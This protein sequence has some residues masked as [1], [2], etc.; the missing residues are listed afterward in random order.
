MQLQ[1]SRSNQ[2]TTAYKATWTSWD[3]WLVIV[4]CVG[5]VKFICL[6]KGVGLSLTGWSVHVE[7]TKLSC[8]SDELDMVTG[9]LVEKVVHVYRQKN[10]FLIVAILRTP[11]RGKKQ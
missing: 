4:W 9:G 3:L 10:C 11:S 8:L 1:G 2:E 6:Q 5:V 7:D